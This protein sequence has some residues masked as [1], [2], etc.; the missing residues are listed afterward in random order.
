MVIGQDKGFDLPAYSGL[1]GY[2]SISVK[3]KTNSRNL[4]VGSSSFLLMAQ[5]WDDSIRVL[6]PP[7]T[8]RLLARSRSIYPYLPFESITTWKAQCRR[9]AK[10]K[11]QK[12]KKQREKERQ[13][14]RKKEKKKKEKG[15]HGHVVNGMNWSMK[16][17]W[18][19]G[20]LDGHFRWLVRRASVELP[21]HWNGTS[22]L[23][24][25]LNYSGHYPC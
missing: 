3:R 5:L 6:R 7:S 9:R 15:R 8:P 21:K 22:L 14:K 2:Y 18:A 4:S 23:I 11:P 10:A 17:K 20:R 12:A 25:F 24:S 19:Q 1:R 16:V 13:K